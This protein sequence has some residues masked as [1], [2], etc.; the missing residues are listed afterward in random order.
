MV[1]YRKTFHNTHVKVEIRL[2][3]PKHLDMND[4]CDVLEAIDIIRREWIDTYN[5]VNNYLRLEEE[6]QHK[7]LGE[8]EG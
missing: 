2:P 4:A 6:K 1:D 3:T 7:M 5:D 8:Y